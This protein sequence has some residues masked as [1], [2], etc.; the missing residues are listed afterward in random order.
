MTGVGG[1]RDVTSPAIDGPVKRSV[2]TFDTYTPVA[3]RSFLDHLRRCPSDFDIL[4][5]GCL[6]G[7]APVGD[8]KADIAV[9]RAKRTRT[10][11][12]S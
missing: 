8:A 2:W 4:P 12:R 6:A 7:N 9:F 10:D 1:R 11:R 5:I 3:A